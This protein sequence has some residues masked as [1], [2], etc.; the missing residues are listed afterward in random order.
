MLTWLPLYV[1]RELHLSLDRMAVISGTYFGL[2]ALAALGC[3]WLS[4]RA[5]ARGRQPE[6]VRVRLAAIGLAGVAAALVIVAVVS[7]ALS[8]AFLYIAAVSNGV[9]GASLWAVTQTLAG[10]TA[11]SALDRRTN[12]L[13]NLAGIAA[14]ALT[15]VIVDRTGQFA[16]AFAVTALVATLGAAAWSGLV[17][18]G[19]PV[20][21]GSA[22]ARRSMDANRLA[23]PSCR[24]PRQSRQSART[25]SSTCRARAG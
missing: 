15:G 20:A 19:R 14:P 8:L 21:W 16:G 3:G 10:V 17:G 1:V 9:T 2:A 24:N 13:G 5:I 7:P 12:F 6:R 25:A 4:D 11:A 18:D 22:S 23:R